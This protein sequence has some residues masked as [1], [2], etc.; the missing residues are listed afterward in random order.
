M[1][2][3]T[4]RNWL[5]RM[6][7]HYINTHSLTTK[8]RQLIF[9]TFV[10]VS[11]L[12]LVGNVPMQAGAVAATQ[13]SAF[14]DTKSTLLSVVDARL[15]ESQGVT[16]TVN[17][18][19]NL[20]ADLKKN[21][22]SDN[23]DNI[24]A[25][26]AIKTEVQKANSTTDLQQSAQKLDTQYSQSQ[27]NVQQ[28]A[29]AKDLNTQ[30]DAS[31]QLQSMVTQAKSLLQQC[32]AQ[33]SS[34]GSQQCNIGSSNS[35][36]STG[37]G[38][39]SGS[40]SSLDISSI[41]SEVIELL[42]AIAAI[43]TSIIAL[44]TAI[45]SGDYTSALTIFITIIGE[46]EIIAKILEQAVQQISQAISGMGGSSS[47][48]GTNSGSDTNSGSSNSGSSSSGKTS[49]SKDLLPVGDNKYTTSGA[50]K[51]YVYVCSQ[52]AQKLKQ[53][54]PGASSRGPWFVNNNTQYDPTQK[55]HVQGSVHWNGSMSNTISGTTRTIKTN[56]LPLSHTTG[57][58]PISSSD[59]AYSY[60]HNPNSIG[61]QSLTYNLPTSPTDGNPQCI[62]NQVGVMLS[63]VLIYSAFDESGR[64]AGAWETQ[65]SCDGHPQKTSK[66][67]YHTLS[68]CI[69]YVDTQTVI[70]FAL[71]GFPITGPRSSS[72]ALLTTNDLDECHG[73]KSE[74]TLDGKKT[75]MYHYVMTRDFPYSVSC[76]RA[77]P[78]SG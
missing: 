46:L 66:Y 78:V 14:N 47:G 23:N 32:Q 63:G 39:G 4:I 41:I 67:H 45:Q 24:Q 57:T 27:F 70:G 64:D 15:A 75:T 38:S 13:Q 34:N 77:T 51:G 71:D 20:P 17:E 48:T 2:R 73:M 56:D 9:G 11:S 22:Q 62:N 1:R 7:R 29:I 10:A 35:G 6:G 52:Y 5:F 25:L 53:G 26:T 60:D 30:Q 61:A 33:S 16:Q 76:F 59:P 19:Q 65:D 18:S 8:L 74:I 31:N 68:N 40:G 43:I 36:S 58:F 21:I 42:A 72:G 69:G 3:K 50:Q 55:I 37:S 44:I 12:L 28:G 54:G 49:D